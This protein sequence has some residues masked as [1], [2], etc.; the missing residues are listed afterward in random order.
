M[1]SNSYTI[2]ARY[3]AKRRNVEIWKSFVSLFAAANLLNVCLW[4]TGFI[5]FSIEYFQPM[6]GVAYSLGLGLIGASFITHMIYGTAGEAFWFVFLTCVLMIAVHMVSLATQKRDWLKVARIARAGERSGKYDSLVGSVG[7]ANTPIDL[8]GNVT[9]NDVN[10]VVFSE[11][12]IGVGENVRI[13]KVTPDK[14]IVEAVVT[15]EQ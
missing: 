11:R 9:V 12:P 3:C 6:R 7:V 10:L 5:L 15:D 2:T 13:V 14:I 8:I 4:T 1:R